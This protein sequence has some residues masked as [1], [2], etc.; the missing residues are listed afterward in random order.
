LEEKSEG[1][2][3]IKTLTLP[4]VINHI[5]GRLSPEGREEWVEDGKE[6]ITREIKEDIRRESNNNL[7]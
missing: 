6:K 4:Q 5:S 3:P 2:N 1:I 7:K